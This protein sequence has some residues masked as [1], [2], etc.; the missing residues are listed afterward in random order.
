MFTEYFKSNL[1]S[2]FSAVCQA[3]TL[4]VKMAWLSEL[5]RI[6][7]NQQKLLRG[8]RTI[9]AITGHTHA[10]RFLDPRTS[11][12]AYSCLLKLQRSNLITFAW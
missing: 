9:G 4:E 2:L 11:I 5:R 6:L 12:R 10:L 1:L 8:L 3:P 7:T